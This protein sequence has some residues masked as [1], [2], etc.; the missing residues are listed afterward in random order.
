MARGTPGDGQAARTFP[1]AC[2]GMREA[3]GSRGGRRTGPGGSDRGGVAGGFAE[4]VL[5]G[6]LRGNRTGSLWGY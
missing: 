5:P 6:P 4:G 2:R 1:R 3:P